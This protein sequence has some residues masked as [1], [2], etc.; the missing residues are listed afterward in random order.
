M[1]ARIDKPV[2]TWLLAWPSFWS[3]A[4]AAMP[5]ELPDMRMLALFAC[6]SVLIRGAGCTINDLLDRDI[7]RKVIS[8]MVLRI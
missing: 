4:M 7:D 5:G 2:G 6:G 3:T 1:L 8:T